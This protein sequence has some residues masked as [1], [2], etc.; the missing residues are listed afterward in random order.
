MWT[1]TSCHQQKSTMPSQADS[2]LIPTSEA[3]P[4]VSRED[5]IEAAKAVTTFYEY[6]LS[7]S[8]DPDLAPFM[9][10]A[11]AQKMQRATIGQD[12]SAIIRAQD[13]DEN[14]RESLS[15]KGLGG[16]WFMVSYA[17]NGQSWEIPVKASHVDG[18]WLMSYITPQP[19]GSAYGD[20]LICTTKP[21][22]VKDRTTPIGF[23]HDFYTAYLAAYGAMP[24]NLADTLDVL[25]KKYLTP[26]ALEQWKEAESA[27]E[28]NGWPGYDLLI[29][30]FDFD[31]AAYPTLKISSAKDGR[32]QASFQ[33]GN[34][35]RQT[36][37]LLV[38]GK[39]GNLRIDRIV[40]K[41]APEN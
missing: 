41:T 37:G 38:T 29:N 6:A 9:T 25:R 23:L 22:P 32:L 28:E 8:F 40:V 1:G 30:D 34:G 19:L 33:S 17:T 15:V 21:T 27:Q 31:W 3:S 36:I 2:N 5:S 26:N 35:V 24:E 16:S 14:M 12:A 18:K 10:K 20:Q 39:K 13:T 11:L 4:P 7:E